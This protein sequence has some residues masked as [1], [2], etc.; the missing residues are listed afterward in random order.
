[1]KKIAL[2]I[3]L[4]LLLLVP[5]FARAETG[6]ELIQNSGSFD[7][8]SITYQGEVI[9]VLTRGNYAWINIYNKGYAIGIWSRAEDAEKISSFG[10]YTHIGDSVS[11][12]GEFHLACPEHGGD[13]D[14]H[15]SSLK[16][17]STGEKIDRMPIFSV[18]TLSVILFTISI[19]VAALVKYFHKEKEKHYLLEE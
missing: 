12:E 1:M 15:A 6:E 10:D 17:L 3:F 2:S 16:I 5:S 11:V 4:I 14:I 13:L 9:G 19:F 8:K 18:A 7:G